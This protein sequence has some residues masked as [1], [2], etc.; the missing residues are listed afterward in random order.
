MKNRKKSSLNSNNLFDISVLGSILDIESESGAIEWTRNRIIAL[1]I[2]LRSKRLVTRDEDRHYSKVIACLRTVNTKLTLRVNWVKIG[3]P[4]LDT[5]KQYRG[6]FT[7][8]S[9]KKFLISQ[10]L[11]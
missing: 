1:G 7:C 6:F 8:E 3:Q 2:E 11:L 9:A 10:G 4:S 5:H